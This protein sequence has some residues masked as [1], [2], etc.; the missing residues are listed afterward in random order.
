M[1]HIEESASLVQMLL[2]QNRIQVPERERTDNPI[3][4]NHVLHQ[5][6]KR[7][8]HLVNNSR[9]ERKSGCRHNYGINVEIWSAFRHGC[10][11]GLYLVTI[12]PLEVLAFAIWPKPKHKE[13][14]VETK[15]TAPQTA[16]SSGVFCTT[17]P[18]LLPAH[19]L[20][21]ISIA[22]CHEKI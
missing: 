16:P 21:S 7:T 6:E 5:S 14:I 19:F 9:I 8:Y 18:F 22:T 2:C 1:M 17:L 15:S 12:K 4:S 10:L 13:K 3:L 20:S 11:L